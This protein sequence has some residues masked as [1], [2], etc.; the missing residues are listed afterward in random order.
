MSPR[1][2][3]ATLLKF[4]PAFEGSGFINDLGTNYSSVPKTVQ[5]H[6][7]DTGRKPV[8][9]FVTNKSTGK[10]YVVEYRRALGWDRGVVPAVALHTIDPFAPNPETPVIYEGRIRTDVVGDQDVRSR[11]KEVT[12]LLDEI[13]D[14]GSAVKVTIGGATLIE[15]VE[16]AIEIQSGGQSWLYEEGTATIPIPP[17]CGQGTFKFYIDHQETILTCRARAY[18]FGDPEYFWRVNGVDLPIDPASLSI[19]LFLVPQFHRCS[20]GR[21]EKQARSVAR[22]SNMRWR[23]TT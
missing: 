20:H 17:I 3:A 12:V 2:S 16:T 10:R 22:R 9:A 11:D 23:R 5:L 13:T 18:G 19:Q 1:P 7:P 21:T 8:A 4:L 14:D 15:E 6:A